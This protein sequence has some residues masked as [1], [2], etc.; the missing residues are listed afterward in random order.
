MSDTIYSVS[1]ENDKRGVHKKVIKYFIVKMFDDLTSLVL[2]TFYLVALWSRRLTH[3]R[4]SAAIN[5]EVDISDCDVE[6]TRPKF[7]QCR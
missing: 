4:Y 5:L 7:A 1:N 6:V 2:R 3:C